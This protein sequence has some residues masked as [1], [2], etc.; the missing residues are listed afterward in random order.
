MKKNTLKDLEYL[1]GTEIFL[2]LEILIWAYTTQSRLRREK[3]NINDFLD[4]L[5]DELGGFHGLRI[6]D[7]AKNNNLVIDMDLLTSTPPQIIN[8]KRKQGL[9]DGWSRADM[10][11]AF[12]LACLLFYRHKNW[13]PGPVSE[14]LEGVFKLGDD[15]KWT[16]LEDSKKLDDK[17]QVNYLLPL[18]VNGKRDITIVKTYAKEKKKHQINLFC[19]HVDTCFNRL[20]KWKISDPNQLYNLYHNVL[21]GLKFCSKFVPKNVDASR[22]FYNKN[23]KAV[24]LTPECEDAVI[25]FNDRDKYGLP[26]ND[27]LYDTIDEYVQEL[28]YW[29]RED[30][31]LVG[32]KNWY[33]HLSKSQISVDSKEAKQ[34]KIKA[35]KDFRKHIGSRLQEQYLAD[36]KI[37]NKINLTAALEDFSYTIDFENIYALKKMDFSS[38]IWPLCLKLMRHGLF[39]EKTQRYLYDLTRNSDFIDGLWKDWDEKWLS[40]LLEDI[41]LLTKPIETIHKHLIEATFGERNDIRE[42]YAEKRIRKAVKPGDRQA[43]IYI[44]NRQG[45]ILGGQYDKMRVYADAKVQ[46]NWKYVDSDEHVASQDAESDV[47]TECVDLAGNQ[48]SAGKRDNSMWG[49]KDYADKRKAYSKMKSDLPPMLRLVQFGPDGMKIKDQYKDICSQFN[50]T[51]DVDTLEKWNEEVSKLNDENRFYKFHRFMADKLFDLDFI[52][53]YLSV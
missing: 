23:I 36:K 44:D 47:K 33:K 48:Y 5:E 18:L 41:N 16:Y 3:S 7:Y 17:K 4:E 28:G 12:L 52:K 9:I 35:R 46:N 34:D 29:I 10:V 21:S 22:A 1:W 31:E 32:E 49:N 43:L 53:E 19:I 42:L 38:N 30:N 13:I 26:D 39:D 37:I 6:R 11:L 14:E 25:I 27:I 40:P 51:W 50:G 2:E 45:Y 8:G 24:N 20:K 15:N